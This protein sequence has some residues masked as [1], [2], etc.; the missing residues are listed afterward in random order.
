MTKVINTGD[1]HHVVGKDERVVGD[2]CGYKI[3]EEGPE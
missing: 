1:I 3:R 2:S